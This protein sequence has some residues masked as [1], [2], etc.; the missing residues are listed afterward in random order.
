MKLHRQ[1]SCQKSSELSRWVRDITPDEFLFG[2]NHH[3]IIPGAVNCREVEFPNKVVKYLILELCIIL[4]IRTNENVHEKMLHTSKPNSDTTNILLS[5]II[6]VL[7]L[8]NGRTSGVSKLKIK[9]VR[10]RSQ[11]PHP[12]CNSIRHGNKKE[13]FCYPIVF[14]KQ[15]NTSQ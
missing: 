11:F 13:L 9:V 15:P 7:P 3:D 8:E 6:L 14:S 12:Q 4:I 10:T 5:T 2:L 1:I